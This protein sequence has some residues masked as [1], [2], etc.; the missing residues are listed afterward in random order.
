MNSKV[1]GALLIVVLFV[2]ASSVLFAQTREFD[3]SHIDVTLLNPGPDGPNHVIIG[4]TV[5]VELEDPDI[6]TEIAV[7]SATADFSQFEGPAAEAM[8]WDDGDQRW[9]AEYTVGAGSLADATAKV[10][11]TA[12]KENGDGQFTQDDT[13]FSVNNIATDIEDL[14]IDVEID[15]E[16]PTGAAIVGSTIQVTFTSSEIIN[17]KVD[18]QAIGGGLVDMT[19]VD[20]TFT[21][22]YLVVAGDFTGDYTAEVLA[23]VSGSPNPGS[24]AADEAILVDNWVPEEA[25]AFV[26]ESYLVINDDPDQHFIHSGDPIT[27]NAVLDTRVTK[28]KIDW[29][30]SN[31]R[32]EEEYDV[33]GGVLTASY[34]PADGE[35]QDTDDFEIAITWLK[36]ENGNESDVAFSYVI[37]GA[38]DDSP[39]VVDASAPDLTGGWD[40]YYNP[41]NGLRFS[42]NADS[43][44]G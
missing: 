38:Q 25:D 15:G 29:G 19:Q 12:S 28:A 2:I 17:A 10:K 4:T 32:V 37:S 14:T 30:Y 43:V 22:E 13:E 18:F 33:N 27:V 1:R 7:E 39:I 26:G 5:E 41:D 8:V 6:G 42:P 31:A 3:A 11:I 44:D 21:A 36:T 40:L 23:Y 34:T 24:A 20:S 35:L 9:K 16:G